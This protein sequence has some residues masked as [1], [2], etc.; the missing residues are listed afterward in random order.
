MMS[1]L[2]IAALILVIYFSFH[3]IAK[4][5]FFLLATT[6]ITIALKEYYHLTQ[7]K[8]FTPPVRLALACAV[9]YFIT[10]STTINQPD[11]DEIPS[12]VLLCSLLLFFLFFFKHQ[13]SALGNFAI[14][15]FGFAYLLLPLSYLVKI[16]YYFPLHSLQDG[17]LWLAYVLIISKITDMGGYFIGKC[18]GK[19]PLAPLISPQKTLEGSLGG[20]FV[21]LLTSILFPYLFSGSFHMSLWQSIWMGLLI[22]VLSQLGDLSE[23]LLKRD[24]GVKDSSKLPGFGGLLDL[25][26]SLVFT[27]PWTYLML[28]LQLVG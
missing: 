11:Y 16:N 28:K 15:I 21:A 17:R 7:L 5:V 8:G 23:S 27:A 22:S 1:S 26:D 24:I 10:F 13:S 14:T 25:V 20:S 9:T 19:T 18:C 12:L 4:V 3:P 6:V 2:G